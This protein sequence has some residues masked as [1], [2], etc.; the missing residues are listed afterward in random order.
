MQPDREIACAFEAAAAAAAP[1][2]RPPVIRRRAWL[3]AAA[4]AASAWWLPNA[5]AAAAPLIQLFGKP[6]ARIERVFAAGP[7]AAVLLSVLAPERLLGWPMA[8]PDRARALLP[9]AVRE[10][11]LLGRLAGRGS[12]VSV[13]SLLALQPQLILDAGTVDGTY[14]STAQRVAEQTG[15]AY[16]LVDGRLADTPRQLREVAALLGV[17]ARGEALAAYA[18]EALARPAAAAAATTAPSVYLARGADGLETALPGSINGEF[19]EA[20]GGRNVATARGGLGRVSM[21]Q[22]LAW[23]PDWIV[24]QDA[25]FFRRAPGDA[26]WSVL[27]AVRGGRL[28]LAPDLPFGWLD[29]PPGVNR[30]LGV[31]WLAGVLKTG[32]VQANDTVALAQTFYRLFYGAAPEREALLAMLDGRG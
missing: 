24:T 2:A 10:R 9:A 1:L 4:G 30:L 25:G 16:A 14:V 8:L 22:L 31:R 21:E 7:P 17:A 26:V 18:D 32:K 13:E 6:P 20:A 11:P 12:T 28:L 5:R 27:P 15:L 19:I 29:G 3:A 23:S